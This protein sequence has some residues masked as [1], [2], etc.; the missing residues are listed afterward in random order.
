M[1]PSDML[2]PSGDDS[3]EDEDSTGLLV[4]NPNRP[5]IERESDSEDSSIEDDEYFGKDD[6]DSEQDEQ[7]YVGWANWNIKASHGKTGHEILDV[8][9]KK[10]VW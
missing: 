10:K 4:A 6:H 2:P 1:I 8:S 3:E 9:P 7:H 5:L